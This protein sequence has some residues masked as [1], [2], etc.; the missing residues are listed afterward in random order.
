MH[1]TTLKE[2]LKRKKIVAGV[3][4]I[5]GDPA[6]VE[7]A[8]MAGY[9]FYI[10]DGE[11]G[12]LPPAA[13]EAAI[14][15][16]RS[17]NII[18]LVRVPVNNA[19]LIG[20]YL[21][22]GAVGVMVPHITN[23]EEALQAVQSAH[24]H[25]EGRRGIGPNRA[26]K[27]ALEATTPDYFS[28]ANQATFVLAQIEDLE[29]VN[30]SSAIAAVPGIDGICI[31]QRDLAVSMGYAGNTGEPAVQEAIDRVM[32]AA[33][34]SGKPAALPATTAR[35]AEEAVRRGAQIILGSLLP[36]LHAGMSAH[37]NFR[38]SLR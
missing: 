35:A 23:P 28:K 5:L 33:R 27:F 22:I 6:L 2:Q 38:I 21:D 3:I 7:A 34:K 20:Q 17:V 19:G 15:A 1:K 32:A 10:L 4:S 14:L 36:L 18:P 9:D 26:N 25:P 12:A 8:A 29:G 13:C 30:N 37:L 11:H 16:A 31:G 24:Y